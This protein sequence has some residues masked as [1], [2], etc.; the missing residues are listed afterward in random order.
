MKFFLTGRPFRTI[1]TNGVQLLLVGNSI[2]L[3][4]GFM[5]QFWLG[6]PVGLA[7]WLIWSLPA[8]ALG[9][10]ALV[11]QAAAREYYQRPDRP[12]RLWHINLNLE[13]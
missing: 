10:L 8:L 11:V 7:G 9:L 13:K 4:S 5:R 6:W 1:P 12:R 2:S 3:A